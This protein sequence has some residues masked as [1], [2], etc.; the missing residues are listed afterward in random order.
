MLHKPSLFIIRHGSVER[1]IFVVRFKSKQI[2]SWLNGEF[3]NT[4]FSKEEQAAVVNAD[5]VNEDN[6][7]YGTEGG[8]D[9]AD[10][11]WL[12]S[13]GEVEKYFH[14]DMDVYNDYWN[15]NMDWYEYALYCYGQDQRVCAKPTAYAASEGVW[16]Y[17]KEDAQ[18]A[19]E[20]GYD[21]SYAVGSGWWWLRSPGGGSDGAAFVYYDGDVNY[22]G[23]V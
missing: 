2:R 14:I 7:F 1:L 20:N 8:S 4:T 10:K 12:M 6:P 11:I 13:L 5:V 15:G 3:Y 22:D 9:T 18:S 17:S 21:M 19:L 16:T 23:H